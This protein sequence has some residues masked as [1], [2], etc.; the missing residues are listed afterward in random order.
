M[1]T[2]SFF[3][4][5]NILSFIGLLLIGGSALLAAA[6]EGGGGGAND[7]NKTKNDESALYN[8]DGDY[9]K[10]YRGF[11]RQMIPGYEEQLEMMGDILVAKFQDVTTATTTTT[12]TVP[13]RILVVGPGH[14]EELI[15]MARAMPRA[16]IT[17][18]ERSDAM[19]QA[20][21]HRIEQEGLA[22]RVTVVPEA[23]GVK[24]TTA[25]EETCSSASA[26][27]SRKED[28]YDA[29]TL[30]NVLHLMPEDQQLVLLQAVAEQVKLGGIL[31]LSG[32]SLPQDYY[33]T[34]IQNVNVPP[35]LSMFQIANRRWERLGIPEAERTRI[36]N[37]IG[38]TIFRTLAIRRMAQE[39]AAY[40]MSPP[41]EVFRGLGNAM[42]FSEKS[43]ARAT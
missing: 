43:V 15:V 39:L 32:I 2:R 14:G 5:L 36:R 26:C 37:S 29:V 22:D 16:L 27:P 13:I 8:F 35:H 34:N 12:P 6:A 18:Y 4:F 25:T 1:T 24:S 7:P 31:L 30:C 33:D 38:T 20:C 28:A 10:A 17:A 3:L 23:F 21:R 40:D 42:W 9:G 19:V 11:I 41:L